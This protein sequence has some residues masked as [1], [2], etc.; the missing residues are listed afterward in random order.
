[1]I[2]GIVLVALFFAVLWLITG[3][4]P[5]GDGPSQR[6]HSKR[7]DQANGCTCYEPQGGNRPKEYLRGTCPVHK[8]QN[9]PWT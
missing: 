2:E 5:W 3:E 4:K 1:M 6:N 8:D 9:T 7:L